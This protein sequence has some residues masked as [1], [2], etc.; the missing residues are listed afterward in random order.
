MLH[1]NSF[2]FEKLEEIVE[3]GEE[4]DGHN[5]EQAVIHSTLKW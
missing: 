4:D 3:E 2:Q 1:I 5:V